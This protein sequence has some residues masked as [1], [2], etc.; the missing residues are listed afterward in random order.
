MTRTC[1][2]LKL[3]CSNKNTPET[4]LQFS[5]YSNI[6]LV[7]ITFTELVLT[8]KNLLVHGETLYLVGQWSYSEALFIL[9][10]I[11]KWINKG[12]GKEN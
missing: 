1:G 6:M 5:S 7:I 8:H 2:N 4:L 11:H 10:F 12:N 3:M 9:G